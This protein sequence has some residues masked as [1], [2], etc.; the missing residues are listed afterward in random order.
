MKESMNH[1]WANCEH[2]Y[3]EDGDSEGEGCWCPDC[4][5]GPGIE[6][7]DD[8][9]DIYRAHVSMTGMAP[10]HIDGSSC[11][12][13]F[14]S[15]NLR[16]AMD[17]GSPAEQRYEAAYADFL[18]MMQPVWQEVGAPEFEEDVRDTQGGEGFFRAVITFD[19][20]MRTMTMPL[21]IA[22]PA[23]AE[24]YTHARYDVTH[25]DCE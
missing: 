7:P 14:P 13:L 2:C 18:S 16:L 8:Y 6:P 19:A 5:Y 21:H 9:A 23:E 12:C 4:I 24:A 1:D 11:E 22:D 15:R 3:H 20:K 17:P 25:P 10:P